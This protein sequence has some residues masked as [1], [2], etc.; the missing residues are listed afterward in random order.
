MKTG[1]RNAEG[2]GQKG[3]MEEKTLPVVPSSAEEG[4]YKL[5]PFFILRHPPK[6]GMTPSELLEDFDALLGGWMGGEQGV[7]ERQQARR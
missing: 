3:I 7:D 6:E 4:D 5:T 2:G 1:V